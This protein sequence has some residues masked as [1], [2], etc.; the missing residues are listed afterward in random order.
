MSERSS[1]QRP[2]QQD[3]LRKTGASNPAAAL[4]LACSVVLLA[5]CAPFQTKVPP[6]EGHITTPAAAK[7]ATP[8][9]EPSRAATLVP[10]PT[11][12]VKPQ[13]YSVVVHEVPV[14]ELLLAL[15]RDT[16]QNIDIHPGLTGLVSLNAINET[17]PAILERLTKQVNLRYRTEGNTII[18]SPDVA[19]VKTYRVNYVNM[20]RDTKSNIGVSGEISST[21]GTGTNSSTTSGSNTTV[22]STSNN[23]FWADLR[24]NIRD[25][26]NSTRLQSLGAEARAE[27]QLALKQQQD[28]QIKQLEAASKATTGA[29]QLA[30]AVIS[31]PGANPVQA[32]LVPEDVIVNPTSGTITINATDYQHQLIQRHLDSVTSA[33]QRQV[34]IEATIVE[35]ILSDAFQAGIDWSRLPISGGLS[36][37]QALLGGFNTAA[38][39]AG[40]TAGNALTIAYTNPTTNIG[41][42]SGTVKLLETFGDSRVLSSPKLMAMNNQTALLKVVDNLVYFEIKADTT[43]PTTGPTLT[44]FNTT[45]KSVSVGV[46]MGVTPQINEDGRVLLN[47]RPTVTR[48]NSQ[49]PFVNDPNPSLCDA[50]RTNCI[51][52]PVPQIQVREMES[53]LQ[54][55]SGQTVILGGLMQ[56]NASVARE[57]IP[58]TDSLG[59]PLA[60]LFRF[61]DQRARKSELVIF[62][63]PTVIPNPS[64]DSDELKYFQ[65]FL[66]QADSRP[67]PPAPTPAR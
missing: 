7:P 47:V 26:L 12:Q 21:T 32:S 49:Q 5:A 54:V 58:G 43:T 55:V 27:R 66:P 44:T 37:T 56:D 67:A 19:Y 65:G 2:V 20:T 8:I 6:S 18:V 25:I 38:T 23:N 41:N 1:D 29:A 63:R 35:V 45:A 53:V 9:P 31:A 16:K 48:L 28:Q 13:T 15:A 34:L 62:L 22:T 14:K 40:A 3:G 33:I 57:Q 59:E 50:T 46:V 61:R 64:L 36:I 30:A 51:A 60:N 42:I 11:A 17:L 24:I 10:P 52:N 4:G 39:A